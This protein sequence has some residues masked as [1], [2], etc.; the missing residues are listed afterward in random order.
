MTSREDVVRKN[1]LDYLDD[2]VVGAVSLP[3]DERANIA[4]YLLEHLAD[5]ARSEEEPVIDLSAIL[6]QRFEEN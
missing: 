2:I 5:R 3:P 1:A 6:Y 4:M